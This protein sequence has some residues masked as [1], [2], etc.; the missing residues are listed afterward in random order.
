M[1]NFMLAN[2]SECAQQLEI[3]KFIAF[4]TLCTSG[5][6]QWLNIV[7]EIAAKSLSLEHW[8]VQ[9]PIMQSI[10]QI[11]PLKMDQ[12]STL[13]LDWHEELEGL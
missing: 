4:G 10:W 2:Q 9:I 1:P 3:N 6:L 12:D 5:C 11:G 8:Q 13:L 7:W